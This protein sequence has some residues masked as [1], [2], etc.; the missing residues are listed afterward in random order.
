[1][2][3][4]SDY[5]ELHLRNLEALSP[6]ADCRHP[7]REA[8]CFL[9]RPRE[10]RGYGRLR[11]ST[12]KS[13]GVLRH[14]GLVPLG[15]HHFGTCEPSGLAVGRAGLVAGRARRAALT[16]AACAAAAAE[17]GAGAGGLAHADETAV[18]PPSIAVVLHYHCSSLTRWRAKYADHVR[19]LKRLERVVTVAGGEHAA[20][21][22]SAEACGSDA[23]SGSASCDEEGGGSDEGH[24]SGDG[25]TVDGWLDEV[26]S[27]SDFHDASV[28]AAF[29]MADAETRGGPSMALAMEAASR[30]VWERWKLQPDDVPRTCAEQAS[31]VLSAR[32]LTLLRAP[33]LLDDVHE[34]RACV[35]QGHAGA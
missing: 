3:L 24:G 7:L 30:R 13:I 1:M 9:H 16:S 20:G 8:T 26:L 4:L 23:G 10:Y 28:A 12:G 32:G 6:S 14:R 27:M 15:P 2:R 25:A 34:P 17:A 5:A 19:A 35:R 21:G 22:T 31:W 11:G 33:L 29:A 18:L